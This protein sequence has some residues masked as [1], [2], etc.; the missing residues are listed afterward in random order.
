MSWVD[1]VFEKE[2][3]KR[4]KEDI[5]GRRIKRKSKPKD[6]RGVPLTEQFP[7]ASKRDIN[8]GRKGERWQN[9]KRA[10][11][12]YR[13]N[14]SRKTIY[15]RKGEEGVFYDD[16]ISLDKLNGILKEQFGA[17]VKNIKGAFVLT[18]K[19]GQP[20]LVKGDTDFHGR[21]FVTRKGVRK[22]AEDLSDGLKSG[23]Y[24]LPPKSSQSYNQSSEEIY[25][26]L[27]RA[28]SLKANNLEKRIGLTGLFIF[29]ITSLFFSIQK[30]RPTGFVT[31]NLSEPNLNIGILL[32]VLGVIGSSWFIFRSSNNE[33]SN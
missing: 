17:S 12:T 14:T 7:E 5:K 24:S 18:T 10:G 11:D 9:L 27:T 22:V 4:L 32:S 6:T 29:S 1:D 28:K 13:E 16:K 26:T 33:I 23:A 21:E 2:R 20:L 8:Y 15:G 3:K 30:L 19:E 31:N 25:K